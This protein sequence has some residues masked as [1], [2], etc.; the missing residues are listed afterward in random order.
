MISFALYPLKNAHN[1][2]GVRKFVNIIPGMTIQK[3][4]NRPGNL[5]CS[6]KA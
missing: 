6:E 2:I 4:R 5:C 3:D 1:F